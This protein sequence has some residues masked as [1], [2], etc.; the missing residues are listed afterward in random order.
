MNMRIT[1]LL[2]ATAGLSALLLSGC[3]QQAPSAGSEVPAVAAASVAAE[4]VPA[5]SA[6]VDGSG[7]RTS[8]LAPLTREDLLSAP[9]PSAC[10]FPGGTLVDGALPNIDRVDGQVILAF[11]RAE[12]EGAP[13]PETLLALDPSPTA[14]EP[15]AVAVLEC[16]TGVL[17]WPDILVTYDTDLR[18]MESHVTSD[19]TGGAFDHLAALSWNVDDTVS[20]IWTTNRFGDEPCC[21]SLQSTEQL[22]YTDGDV[23][24]SLPEVGDVHGIASDFFD[25]AD[26]GNWATIDTLSS[27]TEVSRLLATNPSHLAAVREYSD[28]NIT[29]VSADDQTAPESLLQDMQTRGA[30][31][32]CTRVNGSPLTPNNTWSGPTLLMSSDD[33]GGWE[34]DVVVTQWD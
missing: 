20:F 3:A 34:V 26:V 4:P 23:R 1:P 12:Q 10:G 5:E 18:I 28:G 22:E 31:Y 21:G 6:P 14:G 8:G 7:E 13:S 15:A 27:S 25:A 32:V 17:P 19:Y 9:V 30:D 2:L 11:M 16:D 24:I 33:D 29:C